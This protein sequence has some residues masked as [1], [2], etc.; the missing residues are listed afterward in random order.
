MSVRVSFHCTGGS[1]VSSIFDDEAATQIEKRLR[2]SEDI[3]LTTPTQKTFV[4]FANV[5]AVG[6]EPVPDVSTEA[7]AVEGK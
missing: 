5:A 7:P 4:R 6:F 3:W 1:V 2:D